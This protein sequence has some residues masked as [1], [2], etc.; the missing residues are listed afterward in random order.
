MWRRL[1]NVGTWFLV[2]LSVVILVGGLVGRPILLAA[3][4]TGSMVPVL[5]PG[6]LIVVLPSLG[7]NLGVGDIVVFRTEKDT[8]WIVHRIVG[9]DGANGFVTRG[10]ANPTSDPYPVL[11]RHVVGTVPVIGGRAMVIPRGGLLSLGRGPLS[12]PVVA[13]SALLLGLYLVFADV[14]EGWRSIR[15]RLRP[16]PRPNPTP[17][18]ALAVYC[19]MAATVF[20]ITMVS[21]ASLG[22]NSAGTYKVVETLSTRVQLPGLVV[23]GSTR[24]DTV[25][26]Q[27]PA[28]VPLMVALDSNRADVT[29]EPAWLLI[30]PRQ[31]RD[32]ALSLRAVSPGEVKVRLREA[33]YLPFLPIPVLQALARVSWYLPLVA[34]SLVPAAA[35]LLLALL[36]TRARI[37]LGELRLRLQLL[38]RT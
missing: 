24:V 19:A 32:V 30:G 26:I 12:N 22:T 1:L 34:V 13:T 25:S 29:W 33:V 37:Q 8:G 20:L 18:V 10:D 11:P 4:P 21:L 3:V 9:G 31:T 2:A 36:D 5:K 7:M 35:V 28:P 27:N 14:K 15:L 16:L 6:D 38:L 17:K 23:A